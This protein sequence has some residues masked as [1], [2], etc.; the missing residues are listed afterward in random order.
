MSR[1]SGLPLVALL[2]RTAG[3]M[4]PTT[5]SVA[6]VLGNH[7]GSH[8]KAEPPHAHAGPFD[9]SV[10]RLESAQRVQGVAD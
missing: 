7:N 1:L 3:R 6:A 8:S 5:G 10:E 2:L 4:R 9:A